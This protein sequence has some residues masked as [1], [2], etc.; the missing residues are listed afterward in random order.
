M[1]MIPPEKLQTESLLLRKIE[2][3]DARL[4]FESYACD[5]EVARYMSWPLTGNFEDTNSFVKTAVGWWD[6]PDT[7]DDF[8]YSILLQ[9]GN[10]F[11]GC[12]SAGPHSQNSKYH[13]GL[14]YNIAR[15]FWG[16]GYATE[17][18]QALSQYVIGRPE[19]YRV[20]A[21]V[22]VE[23]PASA[24]VLEK[25]GFAKEGILKRFAVHPNAGKEPRDIFIY[26]LTK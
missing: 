10:R 23:N 4:V 13:W 7:A 20:S 1:K 12:C 11:I 22:D 16:N 2:A 6:Q 24:R 21:V 25:C 17:A 26:A 9:A 15:P 5:P 3:G 19:V 8:V 18:I 14:G